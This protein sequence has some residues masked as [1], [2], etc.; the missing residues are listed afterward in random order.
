MAVDVGLN[1][2]EVWRSVVAY[3]N[4]KP[5]PESTWENRA[6]VP[7]YLDEWEDEVRYDVRGPYTYE[8]P[9]RVQAGRDAAARAAEFARGPADGGVKTRRVLCV[10]VEKTVLA[11][12]ECSRR[13]DAGKWEAVA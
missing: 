13:D 4:R 5:N 3:Q 9:A 8:T 12:G 1:T 11:W 10:T 7:Y 6:T 2:P